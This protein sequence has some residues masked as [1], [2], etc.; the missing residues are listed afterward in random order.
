MNEREAPCE[1]KDFRRDIE[2]RM[3]GN[4]ELELKPGSIPLN[5]CKGHNTRAYFWKNLWNTLRNSNVKEMDANPMWTVFKSVTEDSLKQ[6]VR[7]NKNMFS[8]TV[9]S[10]IELDSTD[11]AN[12]NDS[13]FDEAFFKRLFQLTRNK[14]CQPLDETLS[15]TVSSCE[16][17]SQLTLSMLEEQAVKDQLDVR[18]VPEQL[19]FRDHLDSSLSTEGV[20]NNLKET[21]DADVS[22][23]E[24]ELRSQNKMN[25]KDTPKS[26]ADNAMK[27]AKENMDKNP[28]LQIIK[29]RQDEMSEEK[30][31]QCL[32]DGLRK[33]KRKGTVLRSIQTEKFLG[34]NLEKFGIKLSV[35][36]TQ[37]STE[38][39]HDVVTFDEPDGLPF[40]CGLFQ[41]KRP[42][43]EFPWSTDQP[44]VG[45]KLVAEGV[46]QLSR[47][48]CRVLE[49][50]PDV[51]ATAIEFQLALALPDVEKNLICEECSSGKCS[52]RLLN[53]EEI[54]DSVK[55][56]NFLTADKKNDSESLAASSKV[57]KKLVGRYLGDL[58]LVPLRI[59]ADMIRANHFYLR[60]APCK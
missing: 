8:E 32:V 38:V 41:V 55:M 43:P 15:V 28:A 46:A 54:E 7:D 10:K 42:A 13:D 22:S 29:H 50:V 5:E 39:E 27:K 24:T 37:T 47:D 21:F 12:C 11:L 35:F 34:S 31:A 57:F 20:I 23:I 59:K 53:K 4:A 1:K 36:P 30:V 56:N 51:D 60:S 25:K 45:K 33:G 18:M 17:E 9:L 14:G 3:G 2:L 26:I 40:V 58:S 52:V 49:I 16:G 6:T 19:L 44:M 48:I